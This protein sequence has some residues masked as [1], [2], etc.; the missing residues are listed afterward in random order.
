MIAFI[1][2]TS[3]ELGSVW[4]LKHPPRPVTDLGGEFDAWYP[5]GHLDMIGNDPV[6][7]C[8]RKP[9]EPR[10]IGIGKTFEGRVVW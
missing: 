3:Y 1:K 8:I 5:S 6:S 4:N 7:H 9:R 10:F 2:L